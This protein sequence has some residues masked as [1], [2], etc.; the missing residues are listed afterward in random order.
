MA[1]ITK[2]IILF[3]IVIFVATVVL[4][5]IRSS[6]QSS[7]TS[8]LA[9]S[10]VTYPKEIS[11]QIHQLDEVIPSEREETRIMEKSSPGDKILPREEVK[12]APLKKAVSLEN[13]PL[14]Q[15]EVNLLV[16]E[17]VIEEDEAKEIMKLENLLKEEIK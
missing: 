3:V 15:E 6:K 2:L 8:D 12:A 1:K 5:N 11:K 16:G 14:T 9:R 17:E 7:T 10:K 4:L 13:K